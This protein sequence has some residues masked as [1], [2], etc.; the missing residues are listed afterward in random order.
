MELI[1]GIRERRSIRRFEAKPVPHDVIEEIVSDASYA[2]SWKNCQA[3]RYIYTENREIL[4]TIADDMV[5]GFTYNQKTLKH[6]PGLMLLCY[7]TGRSG[8]ER[9]GSFTTSKGAAFEMFDA[10]CAAETFCLAA[11]ARG[12]GTVI[13]GIFDEEKVAK[14]LELPENMK[15]GCLIYMGYPAES[16]EAPPRKSVEQLLSYHE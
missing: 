3:V 13:T 10:G 6:S 1:Q 9:D 16:P 11:H 4:D 2:P 14:L 8:Y 7:V 15:I 12:I 5:L